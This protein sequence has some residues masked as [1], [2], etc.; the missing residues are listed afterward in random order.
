MI[1]IMTID[2]LGHML[3]KMV[4]DKWRLIIMIVHNDYHQQWILQLIMK[5]TDDDEWL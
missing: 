5:I 4:T 3:K 2:H 1:T